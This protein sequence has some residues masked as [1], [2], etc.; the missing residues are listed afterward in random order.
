MRD[1]LRIETTFKADFP[2]PVHEDAVDH[3]T[4]TTELESENETLRHKLESLER[5]LQCRSPTKPPRTTQTP[6]T[7]LRVHPDV[8][9]SA[10]SKLNGPTLTDSAAPAVKPAGMTPGKKLRKLTARKWD[11]MDENEMDAYSDY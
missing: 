4:Y 1:L 11:L 6:T 3:T 7:D 10:L 5:E 2:P 9:G 8:L